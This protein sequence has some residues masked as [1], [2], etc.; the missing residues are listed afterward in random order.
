MN[1]ADQSGFAGDA[2]THEQ[3]RLQQV[4]GMHAYTIES[5]QAA[6]CWIDCLQPDQQRVSPDVPL[7]V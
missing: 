4:L 6:K 2:Q 1:M 7:L 3:S 5:E